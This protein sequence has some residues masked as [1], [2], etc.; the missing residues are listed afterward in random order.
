MHY[1]YYLVSYKS[2]FNLIL[3]NYDFISN[4]FFMTFKTMK[5]VFKEQLQ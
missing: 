3:K 5:T 4:I 1:Y 2:E